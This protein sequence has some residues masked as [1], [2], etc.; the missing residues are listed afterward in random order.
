MKSRKVIVP[1]EVFRQ[2]E[3][4]QK[5]LARHQERASGLKLEI[6]T[7]DSAIAKQTL[8]AWKVE[9]R[10]DLQPQILFVV[11]CLQQIGLDNSRPPFDAEYVLHLILGKEVRAAVIGDLVEEYR[12][13]LHRFGRRRADFWFYK[14]VFF[15][16]WPFVRRVA[17]RVVTLLWLSRFIS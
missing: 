7:L 6:Q 10:D 4:I 16:I 11:N 1:P 13:M 3:S 2:L 12:L 17:G 14:Q 15:S 8:A 5:S 9:L